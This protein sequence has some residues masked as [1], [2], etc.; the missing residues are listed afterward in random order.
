MDHIVVI[1][2]LLIFL[3]SALI[4]GMNVKFLRSESFRIANVLDSFLEITDWLI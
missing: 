4:L 1:N 3:N 2:L